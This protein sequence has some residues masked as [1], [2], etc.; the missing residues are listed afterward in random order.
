MKNF[1]KVF[2]LCIFLT[3]C[4]VSRTVENGL[5]P[6]GAHTQQTQTQQILTQTE[7]SASQFAVNVIT[8]GSREN[9]RVALTFD[10]DMN[11]KMLKDLRSGKVKSWYD[12]KIIAKLHGNNVPA[13]IFM[14]G[15]WA[16]QYS[17]EVKIFAQDPLLEIENHSWDH[18]G[19]AMPCYG[20]PQAINKKDEIMLAQNIL[21][22]LTGRT[23]I[24]FR[25]PGGCYSKEDLDLVNQQGLETVGWDTVSGDAFSKNAAQIEKNVING[26]S[27]GSIIVMHLNG[28]PNAPKTSTTLP[29]IIKN[30]HA[31]GFEFVLLKDLIHPN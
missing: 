19:F 27:N 15:M 23:P 26:T 28:G 5:Q 29:A 6:D 9:K 17:N 25:F 7:Q 24:F 10:A 20:L 22:Q 14:T 12:E 18:A 30:L 4:G 2:V 8:N 1:I 16:Q 31:K 11:P 3:G 13:T 21:Q